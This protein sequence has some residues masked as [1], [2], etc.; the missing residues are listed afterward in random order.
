MMRQKKFM[1]KSA[2][3]LLVFLMVMLTA[4]GGSG[5]A[6]S[7][8]VADQVTDLTAYAK[9]LTEPLS[10]EDAAI[11]AAIE[12]PSDNPDKIVWRHG[13]VNRNLE[14]APATRA[15]RQFLIELKKRLGD[16][17]EIQLFLGGSLG[18]SA[19][20][21]LGGLQN[22]NVESYGYNV[23]AFAEYT[24]AFMPLDV[25]FLIP[26]FDTA[27]EITNGTPGDMMIQKCID[28][29][30]LRVMYMAAVGMRQITTSN[31]PVAT[32]EDLKG[33]KIRVQNNPLHIGAWEQLG[34]A[35]TPI[36][37]A[38]LFTS[39]QQKVVDGQENPISN[40]FEQNYGEVQS[41]MTISNHM[42]TAGAFVLNN[43]WLLSLPADVQAAVEESA[44]VAKAYSG[45]DLKRCET[46]MLEYI[47]DMVEVSEF[48]EEEAQRF[49]DAAVVTWDA[50]AERIG[51]DYF[52][53][54][55]DE[56]LKIIEQ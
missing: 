30:G 41:Y 5:D 33:L 17:V 51:E 23:G 18:G 53:S 6:S 36:A 20:Q 34:A 27:M 2:A 44:E 43:E 45:P 47:G 25:M 56:M 38:E 42:Y 55:K 14:E 48:S 35:P 16:K 26:D 15:D 19:D 40:V 8:G 3:L 28:D 31:K 21:I 12:E 11:W 50:A 1:Q 22:R 9:S 49:R 29:T 24:N 10:E 13:A 7:G 37:F 4:C 52:N 54:V 46:G 32:L 39:L